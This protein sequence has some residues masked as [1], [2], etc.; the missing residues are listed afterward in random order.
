MYIIN[1][2]VYAGTN[3]EEIR[4]TDA[5]ITGPLMMLLTFSNGEQR[6]FDASILT[7]EAFEP[8]KDEEIFNTFSIS[9]GTLTWL[10]DTID[11]APEYIYAHS[12]EYDSIYA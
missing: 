8:L 10:N 11:C 7:G 2:I 9:Y 4:I 12:Y 3:E 1:G 6:V 5:K